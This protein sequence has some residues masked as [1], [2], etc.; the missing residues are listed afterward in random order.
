MPSKRLS[1]IIPGYN[2]PELWWR[3][4][5]DSVLA[6]IGD[7]DEVICVDDGSEKR[8]Y[9]LQEYAKKD[10]RTKVIYR[11]WNGGLSVARNDALV[12]ARGE[13]ITFV[14]SDDE[15]MP[16]TYEKALAALGSGDAD[17]VLFGVRSIWV[18]EKLY[19]EDIPDEMS[20]RTLDAAS[21]K[22]LY[23]ASLLNYAW[24]KVYRA[25]F[26]KSHTMSFDPSRMP[27]EHIIFVLQCIMA[28]AKWG[29]I[30]H[31]GINYYRTHATLL[32]RYKS[33]YVTGT[34]NA[35]R[36]WHHYKESNAGAI[37]ILGDIGEVSE[38]ALMR[39]EWDNIWRLKT[40]YTLLE[41]LEFAR[42]HPEISMGNAYL[43][44]FKKLIFSVL[45]RWLYIRPVQRWHIKK[46]YPEVK[47]CERDG[48]QEV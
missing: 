1:V 21:V 47:V 9:V 46:V 18:N 33:S 28:G 19:K 14:D 27:C 37:A 31:I 29:A 26:L 13:Y 43:F 8:P 40:P 20:A 30:H 10:S 38:V 5:V 11:E 23:E 24:N 35:S 34:R 6:N 25:S 45:R 3:R 39:G 17:V 16:G 44:F 42:Q 12:N 48:T 4:C 41:R 36:V 32:S 7:M 15:I 22:N 2:N